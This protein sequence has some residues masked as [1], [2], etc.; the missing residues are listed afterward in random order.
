VSQLRSSARAEP[1]KKP[2]ESQD[3]S[4]VPGASSPL[5][6]PMRGVRN[7][8]AQ[9]AAQM[10]RTLKVWRKADGPDEKKEE[11]KEADAKE[12]EGEEAKDGPDE[13]KGPEHGDKKPDEKKAGEGDEKKAD[14]EEGEEAEHEEGEEK[15]D[16]KVQRK[17]F[18]AKKD[19][20]PGNN[21]A[22]NK[23]FDDA[24]REIEKQI[25]RKLS[26]DERRQL[27]DEVSKQGMGFHEIVEHGVAMFRK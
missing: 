8:R 1:V 9:A 11:P 2:A 19:G 16:D 22:Q 3:P 13:K 23:Q 4:W 7:E 18:L 26:K 5:N 10:S 14:H 6:D 25:G 12:A 20:T 17:V 21:Q 15:K 24:V 27:H